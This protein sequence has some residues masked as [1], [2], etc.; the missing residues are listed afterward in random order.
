MNLKGNIR[1]SH[2]QNQ[3]QDFVR[4]GF[5]HL[6]RS[7]ATLS[8]N[9]TDRDR[10]SPPRIE[11]DPMPAEIARRS[12]GPAQQHKPSDPAFLSLWPAISMPGLSGSHSCVS[13]SIELGGDWTQPRKRE[14]PK[15]GPCSTNRRCT[16]PTYFL[17]NKAVQAGDPRSSRCP[18]LA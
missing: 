7:S 15:F 4:K 9:G 13:H 10:A 6:N 14:S 3:I 1:I 2:H 11:H 18:T 8:V 16:F 12:A 5:R 17:D